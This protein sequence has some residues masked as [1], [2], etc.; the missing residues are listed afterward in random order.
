VEPGG[1]LGPM[2]G[3]A[4]LDHAGRTALWAACSATG[5]A[6]FAAQQAVAPALRR[7]TSAPAYDVRPTEAARP[8]RP[9]QPRQAHVPSEL[10]PEPQTDPPTT[11]KGETDE[12]AEDRAT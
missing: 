11:T 4:L 10:T 2:L 9:N 5:L 6:L 3:T 7:R 1:V 8:A 12:P